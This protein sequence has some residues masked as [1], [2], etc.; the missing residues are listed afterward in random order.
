[1]STLSFTT[2]DANN[3]NTASSCKRVKRK[4]IY[5]GKLPPSFQFGEIEE[6]DNSLLAM[7]QDT[8]AKLFT[9]MSL[10]LQQQQKQQQKTSKDL[11]T[12][13][14]FSMLPDMSSTLANALSREGFFDL[15]A[16]DA[17]TKADPSV[18]D[19]HVSATYGSTAN[20]QTV[21]KA[22]TDLMYSSLRSSPTAGHSSLERKLNYI[23][24]L[25]EEQK[26]QRTEQ[27][28]EE[29]LL[30]TFLGVF[31]IFIVDSFAGTAA[32]E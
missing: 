11:E 27:H 21:D 19:G 6:D 3:S 14:A 9:N 24:H 23:I 15:S 4:S 25:L 31:L 8:K 12:I 13:R 30:Y 32:K 26:R 5:E 1:M 2:Y 7:N 29:F 18:G 28:A 17:P 20:F 22:Y 10:P 16:A